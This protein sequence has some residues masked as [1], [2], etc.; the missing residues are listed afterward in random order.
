MTFFLFFLNIK[1]TWSSHERML[2]ETEF[3][4]TK[5]ENK[6]WLRKGL[7]IIL[8]KAKTFLSVAFTQG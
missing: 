6:D 2:G 8:G 4:W 3:W 7:P 1:I 5:R